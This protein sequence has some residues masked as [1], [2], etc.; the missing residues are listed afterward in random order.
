MEFNSST[1]IGQMDDQLRKLLK[2]I[3]V[4][5]EGLKGNVDLVIFSIWGKVD[6]IKNESP[7]Q[8]VA[9]ALGQS[10]SA[11][12]GGEIVGI[13][14]EILSD[15]GKSYSWYGNAGDL[16]LGELETNLLNITYNFED[17]TYELTDEQKER[18]RRVFS[19]LRKYKGDENMHGEI[20]SILIG[21]ILD[22]FIKNG[23][24]QI[25][26]TGA[27]GTGKTYEVRKRFI[28]RY[29]DN[30]EFVQFHPSYDYT[31]FVEGIRP[32]KIKDSDTST[33]VR[34]DGTFKKFCRRIVEKNIEQIRKSLPE[35]I[36][37]NISDSELLELVTTC[38]KY[39]GEIEEVK[40]EV[41]YPELL[42]E[43]SK[44]YKK[45]K[46]Y[47]LDT[48]YFFVIDE[49]NR[50]DLSK[51]FGELMFGLE[52]SYRGVVNRFDT[53]YN[54]LDT[55]YINKNGLAKPLEFDCFKDGF[56]IPH[57]LI[58]IGTMNDIDRSVESFDFALR[59]RFKWIDIKANEVMLGSLKAILGGKVSDDK[60]DELAENAKE[61]NQVISSKS[62]LGLNEAFNIGPAYF[63]DYNGKNLDHIWEYNIQPILGE[64]CRGRR[65]EDVN[66]FVNDCRDKLG[67]KGSQESK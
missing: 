20:K 42:E 66:E 56:F 46:N 4:N 58:V 13:G 25:I 11:S 43:L 59:R 35:D 65:K 67:I 40:E 16:T 41:K 21:D 31:D 3:R 6:F 62:E 64:Y 9:R 49:I 7:H 18:I 23:N 57:N 38:S 55:Y 52:E 45:D 24:Y 34:L 32:V 63:K 51:V 29:G 27:P 53:Q 37:N 12:T 26:L 36:I 39:K 1:I 28:E 50:A 14:K 47:K 5:F 48:K 8:N 17:N 61:M 33:F 19:D 10:E 44:V 22:K 2:E 54:N 60:I 15:L 30:S